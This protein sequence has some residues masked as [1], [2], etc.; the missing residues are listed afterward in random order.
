MSA[1]RKLYHGC[2]SANIDS[3]MDD[4]KVSARGFFMTPDINIAKQYGSRV[5]C[6]EVGDFESH[7]GTIN[8]GMSDEPEIDSGFE[9]VL[10]SERHLVSFYKALDDVYEVQLSSARE[11][12]NV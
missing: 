12:S 11:T 6:F 2:S 9:Y 10:K 3:V 4:I 8:K 1:I 7:I 5:V